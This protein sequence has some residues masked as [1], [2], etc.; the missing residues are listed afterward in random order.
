MLVDVIWAPRSEWRMSWPGSMHSRR[1]AVA[2]SF[3]T[4]LSDS[5]VSMDQAMI[6]REKMTYR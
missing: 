3:L 5:M 2:I 6:L 4:T 1:Q